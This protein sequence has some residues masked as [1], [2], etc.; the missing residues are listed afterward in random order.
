MSAAPRQ[1]AGWLAQNYEKL[2]LVVLLVAL[3]LSAL[4]LVIAIGRVRQGVARQ[5]WVRPTGEQRMVQPAD[6]N[7]LAGELAS[8]KAPFQTAAQTEQ[9]MVSPLRVACVSCSKPVD[10]HAA[11]CPFCGAKQPEIRDP[12][13][14]DSDGDGLPDKFELAQGLDPFNPADAVADKDQDGFTNLEEYLAGTSPSDQG[15]CPSP[16]AKLRVARVVTHPFKLRFQGVQ[17]MPDGEVRYLLNLRSLEQSYFVKIGDEV[18][19]FTVV[20]YRENITQGPYGPIDKS[21][22]ILQ[23]GSETIRLVKNE[24]RTEYE[25]AATL[26][27]LIDAERYQ[28]RIGDTFKLKGRE[29]KVIDIGQDRVRIRDVETGKDATIGRISEGELMDLRQL[30]GGGE[31]PLS[32]PGSPVPG[33]APGMSSVPSRSAAPPVMG[34]RQD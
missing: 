17:K 30:R 5:D 10:Y 15:D 16:M 14:V 19:G 11:S 18:E 3:L 23:K 13:K 21:E 27:F 33:L 29:Y 31:T 7:A 6:T 25:R 34:G 26:I 9:M 4:Y 2:I 8:L 1:Q 32:R 24:L 28:V 20:E 22:L 12:D